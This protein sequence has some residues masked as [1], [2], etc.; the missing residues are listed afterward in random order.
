MSKVLKEN[1]TNM[2]TTDPRGRQ[3]SYTGEA[4]YEGNTTVPHGKGVI[5]VTEEGPNKGNTYSGQ[6]KAGKMDGVGT[7][8]SGAR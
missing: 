2:A 1:V 3:A 8:D 4:I 5:T 6:F 7:W